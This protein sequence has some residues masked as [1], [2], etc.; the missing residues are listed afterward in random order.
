MSNLT[1][2]CKF[3]QLYFLVLDKEKAKSDPELL[4]V[5]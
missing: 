5:A 2:N 1:L 4:Q 3:F